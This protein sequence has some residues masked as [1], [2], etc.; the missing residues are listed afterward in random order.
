MASSKPFSNSRQ[1]SDPMQAGTRPS[2]KAPSRPIAGFGRADSLRPCKVC[3]L[4]SLGS[5]QNSGAANLTFRFRF[6]EVPGHVAAC[7]EQNA[8]QSPSAK[9]TSPCIFSGIDG[10]TMSCWPGL[11]EIWT[12]AHMFLLSALAVG[13][14]AEELRF[15]EISCGFVERTSWK[16]HSPGIHTSTKSAKILLS[17]SIMAS[18]DSTA[19]ILLMITILIILLV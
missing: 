12:M 15:G 13:F 19:I 4:C 1:G 17:F 9:V 7:P 16:D 6:I 18:I 5:F 8:A 2:Q 14:K 11:P 3:W 10:A